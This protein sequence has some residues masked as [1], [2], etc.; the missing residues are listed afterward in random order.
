MSAEGCQIKNACRSF[1]R[2]IFLNGKSC[3]M[4]FPLYKYGYFCVNLQVKGFK[5]E[6][7]PR[8]INIYARQCLYST[9]NSP[10]MKHKTSNNLYA[11]VQI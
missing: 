3:I 7:G 6:K 9:A 8:V 10:I 4:F 1:S 11:E 5:Y 2:R